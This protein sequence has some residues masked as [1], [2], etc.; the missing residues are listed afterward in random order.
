MMA[1]NDITWVASGTL[2]GKPTIV[3]GCETLCGTKQK[4]NIGFTPP[5]GSTNEIEAYKH[6]LVIHHDALDS[7]GGFCASK[8]HRKDEGRHKFIATIRQYRDS[9]LVQ[10][11]TEIPIVGG[12]MAFFPLNGEGSY[13]IEI[14]TL[15]WGE[16]CKMPKGI[17]KYNFRVAESALIAPLEGK[18]PTQSDEDIPNYILPLS[19]IGAI[20]IM[21][22]IYYTFKKD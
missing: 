17:G 10:Q 15:E 4:W 18:S 2:Y 9:K 3:L 12:T 21:T 1:E 14:N 7:S 16:D 13:K 6:Q 20:G 19:I 22:T 8:F 5:I 11:P